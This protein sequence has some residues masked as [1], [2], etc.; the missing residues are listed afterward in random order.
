MG[1]IVSSK[2][3]SD[4]LSNVLDV[5]DVPEVIRNKN[6]LNSGYIKKYPQ[7]G[8]KWHSLVNQ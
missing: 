4:F 3:D 7:E 8:D 2:V 1:A 5:R 6:W